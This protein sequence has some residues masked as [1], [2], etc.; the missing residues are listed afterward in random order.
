MAGVLIIYRLPGGKALAV[1]L[2]AGAGIFAAIVGFASQQAFSNIVGGIFIVIFKPFRVDDL[3]QVGADRMGFVVDITLRHTVIR[4][5]NNRR[6][7][8]PNSV[9]S[10]ETVLNFT[11][12]DQKIC[13]WVEI[14]IS[15]DSDINLAKKIMQEEALKHPLLIDNRTE[16]D[17]AEGK[18][19]V[20]VR[21]IGFGDSSV[22]LRA[23]IWA[24]SNGEAFAIHTDL[25]ESIKARF[26]AEGIEIPFP[27]RTL[28]YKDAPG[29]PE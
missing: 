5:F 6:I 25:N 28:V 7:I 27:Y 15:Y 3:I 20:D 26:D 19:Q 9:I 13:R 23:W 29:K 10:A 21:V 14:G 17:I 22:N 11:I 18:P 24:N 4:D 1:S 8:I 2:F 12:E 16:E